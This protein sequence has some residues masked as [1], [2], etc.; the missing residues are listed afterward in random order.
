MTGTS[1]VLLGPPGAGKGTQAARLEAASGF[2]HVATGDMLRMARS[3]GT[4][5][6]DRAK[7]YM[8]RGDLVPDDVIIGLIEERLSEDDAM[9]G[10]ILDGFPRNPAQAKELDRLMETMGREL[11]LAVHI[12]VSREEVLARL[13]G[14]LVCE[15]CQE[16]Y[17]VMTRPPKTIGVCDKCGGRLVTRSDDSPE[18]VRHRLQV[19][20]EMTAP[21]IVYYGDLGRLREVDG[22]RPVDDVARELLEA[23]S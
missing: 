15:R 2:P 20:E 4:P 5:L 21:L 9:K 18:T 22:E 23:I 10:V 7:A 19:Y 14:R 11:P 6:G 3:A 16:A 17:H 8:D 12:K 1:L 13:T